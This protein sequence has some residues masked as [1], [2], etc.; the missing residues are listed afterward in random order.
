MTDDLRAVSTVFIVD[1][2]LSVRD[3]LSLLL[4]LKGY[5]TACFA[6]AEDFLR[7]EPRDAVGCVIADIKMPGMGGLELQEELANR[8]WPLPVIV[9][10]AHGSVAAAR[11][12]FRAAA[13]DLLEKPFDDDQLVAAVEAALVR[14]RSRVVAQSEQVRRDAMMAALSER[15]RDVAELLVQGIHNRGIGEQLGISPRTVEIHKARILAKLGVRTTAE[16]IRLRF[17]ERR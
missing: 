14:E 2:D 3:S 7:T 1:D 9:I 16:L 5:R 4:S 6:C 17:A 15:E 10:T 11:Q 13:V 12:A 8:G